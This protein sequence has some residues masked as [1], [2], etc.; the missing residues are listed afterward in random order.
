MNDVIPNLE[1]EATRRTHLGKW[2]T[3]KRAKRAHDLTR[4][5]TQIVTETNERGDPTW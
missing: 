5:L 2:S 3:D 4:R 1:D